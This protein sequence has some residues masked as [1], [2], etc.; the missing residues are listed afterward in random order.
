VSILLESDSFGLA[1]LDMRLPGIS[2]LEALKAMRKGEPRMRLLAMSVSGDF[3]DDI[4]RSAGA[5][6]FL[7]KPLSTDAFVAR[8]REALTDECGR[9][10]Q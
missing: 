4:V 1:V 5:V 9:R 8:I 3:D 6:G 7:R 2:G 10:A